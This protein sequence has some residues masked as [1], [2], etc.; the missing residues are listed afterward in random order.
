MN[1]DEEGRVTRRHGRTF[2]EKEPLLELG[3]IR[4]AVFHPHRPLLAA[5][6]SDEKVQVW[7]WER[8]VLVREFA[9]RVGSQLAVPQRFASDGLRLAVMLSS[10][11]S[12]SGEYYYREWEIGTGRET[13]S[14][15]FPEAKS[16][17]RCWVFSPD[18]TMFADLSYP[19]GENRLLDLQ[20]GRIT[21][22]KLNVL[23]PGI[24]PG[25]S[26]DGRLL[27][28]PSLRSSVRIFDVTA[29]REV[30]VLSGYMFGVHAA[31]FAPDGKRVV[32]G[33]TGFEAIALWDP[34]SQERVL[35]LPAK[36][37]V[38]APV[39]FSADGNVLV[40]QSANTLH[41]WRAPS[42]AEIEAADKLEG[43]R[44]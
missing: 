14:F 8:R 4:V 40:G 38:L 20:S 19:S 12:G 33:G 25:F 17:R 18:G 42:W 1:A 41:F 15:D 6:T 31:A 27:A 39:E 26:P 28:V 2:Q 21:P 35:T 32:S 16:T 23:E 44:R 5:L 43:S 22:L 24:W 9:G 29:N 10:G 36:A 34:Q 7:D 11:S 30:A 13:R 37:T 3:S